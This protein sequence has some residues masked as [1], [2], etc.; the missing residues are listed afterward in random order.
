MLNI[1]CSLYKN[2]SF[3]IYNTANPRQFGFLNV[4][5]QISH[6]KRLK[7]SNFVWNVYSEKHTG[8]CCIFK[9]YLNFLLHSVGHLLI[10]LPIPYLIVQQWCVPT[11]IVQNPPT[12][13]PCQHQFIEQQFILKACL[14]KGGLELRACT[15][16]RTL[17]RWGISP[18]P[19]GKR[20]NPSLTAP[21]CWGV[22]R[23]VGQHSP[24]S[25]HQQMLWVLPL[26][27]LSQ[28]KSLQ[29]DPP[30]FQ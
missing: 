7:A 26:P 23:E 12:Y 16:E 17:G 2:N 14:F 15:G 19:R 10:S 8:I 6:F 30:R 21:H 13:F 22:H 11:P 3:Y 28:R 27:W 24:G 1:L 20:C 18:E 4:S 5:L 29:S 9:D 25:K